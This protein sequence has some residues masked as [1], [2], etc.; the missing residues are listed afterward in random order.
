MSQDAAVIRYLSQSEMLG[1]MRETGL[2]S[3]QDTGLADGKPVIHALLKVINAQTGAEL[4]GG[5]PFSVVMFKAPAEAGYS[6]IAIGTVVP[7]T[8]LRIDL[9]EDFFNLCNQRFRF[10]RAYPL[11]AGSFVLQLDL[12]L[13]DATRQYV[14]FMFG[15]WSAMFSQVLF[16]LMGSNREGVNHAAQVY[17]S[18]RTA[19]AERYAAAVAAEPAAETFMEQPAA[20][21]MPVEQSE[22]A[23]F[24]SELPPAEELPGVET[25]ANEPQAESSIEA[26]ADVAAAPEEAKGAAVSAAEPSVEADDKADAEAAGPADTEAQ[27]SVAPDAGKSPEDEVPVG[28]LAATPARELAASV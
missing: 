28:A 5:L 22:V 25:I 14:K 10:I 4:P 19:I 6:N 24:I 15:L 9:P 23:Q 17:A 1:L 21:E 13:R 18:L 7:A 11:D 26:E 27:P 2:I 3:V 20:D 8:E 12:F 16:E